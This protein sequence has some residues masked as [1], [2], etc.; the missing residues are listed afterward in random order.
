MRQSDILVEVS[1]DKQT[2]TAL[3]EQDDR[4]AYLYIYAREDLR[5][6]FPRMR[7]CWIRNLTPAP[8][9]DDHAAMESGKAPMTARCWRNIWH[10]PFKV[11]QYRPAMGPAP[12]S[13]I[14]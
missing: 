2:L 6:R 1:N 14:A 10:V 13:L 12:S 11:C 9:H 4:V 5:D 8:Q 3:V 7:A